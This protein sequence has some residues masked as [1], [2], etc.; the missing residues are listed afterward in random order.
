SS[1]HSSRSGTAATTAPDRQ[2]PRHGSTPG[3]TRHAWHHGQRVHP[4]AASGT[5]GAPSDRK[6][7][8]TCRDRWARLLADPGGTPQPPKSAPA[9]SRL[10]TPVH[11]AAAER[12]KAFGNSTVER[13]PMTTKMTRRSLR[14][15][16]PLLGLAVL[17]TSSPASATPPTIPTFTASVSDLNL[18]TL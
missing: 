13:S 7:S 16:A 4:S 6:C 14:A 5:A 12:R 3:R 1:T 17:A 15:T 9:I 10:S 8:S 18:V 11:S 2:A